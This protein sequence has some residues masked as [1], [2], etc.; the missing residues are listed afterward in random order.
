M[1]FVIYGDAD[2]LAELGVQTAMHQWTHARS[3]ASF[4]E[5]DAKFGH[6]E[7]PWL[8]QGTNHRVVPARWATPNQSR[9]WIEREEPREVDTIEIADLDALV[10]LAQRF[11]E[12]AIK[13]SDYADVLFEINL[14][15]EVD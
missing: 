9:T 2:S 15:P 11:T 14:Q 7:G 10:S 3:I 6:S 5:F 1:K 8:S 12:L 4:E 13:R